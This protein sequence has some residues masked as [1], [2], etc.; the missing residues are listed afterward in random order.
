VSIGALKPAVLFGALVVIAIG[1]VFC[2]VRIIRGPSPFDRV[3]AFDCL[4]LN[5][6]GAIL[7]ESMLLETDVY[8]D[9]ALV[10]LLFGFLGTIS[11]TTYLDRHY[12]N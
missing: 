8:V 2:L 4:T 7:L 10:V 11:L 5:L 3:L 6:V 1:V 9:V 12:G